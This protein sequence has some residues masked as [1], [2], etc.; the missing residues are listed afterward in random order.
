MSRLLSV[1]P[2]GTGLARDQGSGGEWP[3]N[4]PELFCL[5]LWDFPSSIPVALALS[6]LRI[7]GSP[8][9]PPSLSLGKCIPAKSPIVFFPAPKFSLNNEWCPLFWSP[10]LWPV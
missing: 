2:L 10:A 7:S 3:P 6:T 9:Q 8:A 5:A 4:L 1:V